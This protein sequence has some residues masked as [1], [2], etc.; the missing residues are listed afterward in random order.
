MVEST[1]VTKAGRITPDCLGLYSDECEAALARVVSAC[2]KYGNSRL[3]IQLGH[4]GRKGS[5]EK[6]ALGGKPLSPEN[7]WDLVGADAVAYS[8][9]HQVP[10]RATENDLDDLIGAYRS[11]ALRAAK[12]GFDILELHAAH[13]YLLHSFLSPVSNNRDDEYGGS[14]QRRM[15]FPLEVF[16]AVRDVWP[17]DRALGVRISGFD[18]LNDPT[19][20]ERATV[21]A[22]ELEKGGCDYVTVSSGGIVPDLPIQTGPCYQVPF[23]RKIRENVGMA[24]GAVGMINL[25]GSADK[26][27][28]EGTADLI[29]IGREFLNDPHSL[30]RLEDIE[31]ETISIPEQY[32]AAAPY[33]WK[34]PVQSNNHGPEE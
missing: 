28:Q 6:P 13:G 2:R 5:L 16:R 29:F 26:I 8:A 12:L 14:L 32:R 33:N 17:I 9:A 25:P 3:G 18:W 23:A 22:Q 10:R 4:A 31:P 15:R 1:A 21:F 19:D 24:V 7:A 34:N 11:A 27:I 20:L 30:W